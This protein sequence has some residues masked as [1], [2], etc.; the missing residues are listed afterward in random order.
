MGVSWL[1]EVQ[2]LINGKWVTIV[3]FSFNCYED[4]LVFSCR[5]A[6]KNG[7]ATKCKYSGIYIPSNNLTVFRD[8]LKDNDSDSKRE[9]WYY[10]AYKFLCLKLDIIKCMEP[11]TE[12]FMW[13]TDFKQH[14]IKC[15]AIV[16]KNRYENVRIHISD[17]CGI[18]G[19]SDNYEYISEDC[20]EDYSDE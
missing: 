5:E 19:C 16:T 8:M 13:F 9:F 14:M 11:F 17:D 20:N 4:P 3:S 2:G 18:I 15:D 1:T 10:E 12:E 6:I 7:I